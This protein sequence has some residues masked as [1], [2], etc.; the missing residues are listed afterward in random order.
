LSARFPLTDRIS[1][2]IGINYSRMKVGDDWAADKADTVSS[3]L[4]GTRE[5]INM[6]S[7]PVS[8]GYTFSESFSASLGITPFR[9]LGGKHI[10]ILQRNRW[11]HGSSSSLDTAGKLIHERSE[12]SRPDS[13]YRGNTYWG[14]VQLSGHFSP[15]F[16]RRYNMVVAPYVGIPVGRLRNDRNSWLHGGV[17]LRFYF[18]QKNG[19]SQ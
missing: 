3:Q 17:S 16:F 1:A 9:A 8:L 4:V 15:A 11:V 14:F 5:I 12:M 10:D 18:P 6:V 13:L 2:E 7:V 19:Y